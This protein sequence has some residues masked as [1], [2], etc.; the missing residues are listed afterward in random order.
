MD[1]TKFGCT[2]YRRHK[3]SSLAQIQIYRYI[4]YVIWGRAVDMSQEG[5]GGGGGGSGRDDVYMR[6]S[7]WWKCARTAFRWRQCNLQRRREGSRGRWPDVAAHNREVGNG[8]RVSAPRRVTIDHRAR[9][10][11]SKFRET[12]AR[13]RKRVSAALAVLRRCRE[14]RYSARLD[15]VFNSRV[16]I[17]SRSAFNE[18]YK[19][20]S[21]SVESFWKNHRHCKGRYSR[22]GERERDP[23]RVRLNRSGR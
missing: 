21:K 10:F 22:G 15:R 11:P 3:F 14:F 7:N 23:R 20:V 12:R 18:L 2:T 4:I 16:L 19:R 8:L 1:R 5:G 9:K 6:Q 13:V 17:D